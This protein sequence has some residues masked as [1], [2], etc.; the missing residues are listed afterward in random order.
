LTAK[1][2]NIKTKKNREK[3][4]EKRKLWSPNSPADEVNMK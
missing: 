4:K 1:L 3:E 2:K